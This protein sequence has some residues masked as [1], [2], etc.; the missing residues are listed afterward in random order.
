MNFLIWHHSSQV[1]QDLIDYCH[2][3]NTPCAYYYF[4]FNDSNRCRR[5]VLIQSVV[6]QIISALDHVPDCVKDLHLHSL[7]GT[8]APTEDGLLSI[9]RTVLQTVSPF[10]LTIDALDECTERSELLYLVKELVAWSHGNIKV[11]CFSRKE[12][13]IETAMLE[14]GAEHVELKPHQINAD[15]LLHIQRSIER[16]PRLCKW[17][18]DVKSE[19]EREL[20]QGANGM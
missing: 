19:I 3:L 16:H 8:Q 2:I 7:E 6:S 17:K 9:L 1:V 20:I 18:A 10:Y 4:D 13:D 11:L 12:R 5:K 15:I 14:M